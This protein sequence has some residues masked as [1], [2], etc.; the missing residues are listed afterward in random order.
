M[1][2]MSKR[3]NELNKEQGASS[4]LITLPLKQEGYD[5]HKQLF[6]DLIRIRYGWIITK[7]PVNCECGAT[8]IF[9]MIIMQERRFCLFET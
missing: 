5:L 3:L 6:K 1:P 8:S 4:W 7:L 2:W 9:N